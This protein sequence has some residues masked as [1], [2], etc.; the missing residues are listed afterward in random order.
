MTLSGVELRTGIERLLR[1]GIERLSSRPS[2]RCFN[3]IWTEK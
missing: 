2:R 3:E 1:T